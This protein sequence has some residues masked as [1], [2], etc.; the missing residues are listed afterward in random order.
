MEGWKEVLLQ[1]VAEVIDSLHKTPQYSPVGFP[2]VRV[3]DIKK[4]KLDL[5]NTLKVDEKTYRE[6]SKKHDPSQGDI[7]FSRVGSYGVTSYV[8]SNDQFC[9]GQN[10][11]FIIPKEDALFLYYYLNSP[12][13]LNEIEASVAG[14]TQATISLKSINNFNVRLPSTSEQQAIS[15]VLSSLDD[16]IDLLHRQNK[17]LEAL[18]QTLFRQWFVEEADENIGVLGSIIDLF[19]GKALKEEIRSGTGFPVFGS[20]GIVGYHS[21]PLVKGPGIVIGRK[22]T[23]GNAF[24]IPSDFFPIDT[25]YYIVPKRQR[26]SMLFEYFLLKSLSFENSDS[27]VPGLNREIALSHEITIPNENVIHKFEIVCHDLF[28]KIHANMRKIRILTKLRDNLLP[29]IMSGE[30]RVEV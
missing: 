4:G 27:A 12:T 20:N 5:S 26:A 23:L 19:Y 14:S 1:E 11:A 25:T 17:T 24:Y 13:G 18:A 29:K 16:K 3:T 15:A 22:G 7:V 9:L 21:E 10:T 6:F 2:M 28:N 30:V 8:K